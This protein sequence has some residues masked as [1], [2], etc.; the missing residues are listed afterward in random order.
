M[1]TSS[2]MFSAY[3]R[4]CLQM[5]Y[6]VFLW[7]SFSIY[8]KLIQFCGI[9]ELGT[10]YPKDMFDPHG[11]SEDSYYEA[12]GEP[13][14]FFFTALC[15]KNSRLMCVFSLQPK[16]RK[17]RWTNWRKRRR[18]GPRWVQQQQEKKDYLAVSSVLCLR[19][20]QVST[21]CSSFLLHSTFSIRNTQKSSLP[22]HWGS[23][24]AQNSFMAQLCPS[25]FFH[26]STN[27]FICSFLRITRACLSRFNCFSICLWCNHSEGAASVPGPRW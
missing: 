7:V 15:D 21:S 2:F 24:P 19:Q 18:S 22:S 27:F 13:L 8:E 14:Y 23:G 3:D 12:L 16:P 17:W 25:V 11:W 6:Q 10:N 4:K 9:D 20:R 5:I 26:V 1:L